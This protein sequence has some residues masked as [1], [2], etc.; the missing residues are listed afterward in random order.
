MWSKKTRD[1]PGSAASKS[2]MM[3]RILA[4]AL[5]FCLLL[6]VQAIWGLCSNCCTL[7]VRACSSDSSAMANCHLHEYQHSFQK[8]KSNCSCDLRGESTIVTDRQFDPARQV[9]VKVYSHPSTDLLRALAILD[10]G[11]S[12][13]SI[14]RAGSPFL[15]SSSSSLLPLRI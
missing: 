14:I 13:P 7:Q 15:A 11:R 8:S 1:H 4:S 6:S 3:R 9:K 5:V 12:G 2:Y 10:L